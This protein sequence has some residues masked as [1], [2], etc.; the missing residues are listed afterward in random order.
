MR[1]RGAWLFPCIVSNAVQNGNA[2]KLIV[3]N[4]SLWSW[5]NRIFSKVAKYSMKNQEFGPWMTVR[6]AG[7]MYFVANMI[8]DA[9]SNGRVRVLH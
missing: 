6:I 1:G 5:V 9:V 8:A 3:R 4:L 7:M 2:E